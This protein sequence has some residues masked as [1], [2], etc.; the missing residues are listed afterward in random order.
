MLSVSERHVWRLLAAYRSRDAPALAHGN[1]GRRTHNALLPALA[2]AVVR[3][4]AERYPGANHTHLSELLWEHE[5][6]DRG[7]F[8][9]RRILEQASTPS[10][11]RRRP[12]EHRVRRAGM[13]R[14]GMLL[15]ID[16]S[17]H[18]WLEERGPRFTLLL[19]VDD[20]TG[21]VPHALFRPTEDAR[22]HLSLMEQV[23][24]RRGLP[25]ALHSDRHGVCLAPAGRRAQRPAT[26][27]V[28]AMQELGITQVFA[29]S[30][31]AKGRVERLTGTSWTGS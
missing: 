20:A 31:Q 10:P 9:V 19:V 15:Q 12:P 14:E 22:G 4:A 13:P 16:G 6:L 21:D 2:E 17:H 7:R 29:R 11:R 28:R 30:P 18:A 5:G 24:Q 1:R 27:F 23:V 8:T 26:V 25:L 3:F